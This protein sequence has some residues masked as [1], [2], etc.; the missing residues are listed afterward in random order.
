MKIENE[1]IVYNC[2]IKIDNLA[3]QSTIHPSEG[4]N[5]YC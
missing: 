1:H 2:K 3:F 5:T 4:V